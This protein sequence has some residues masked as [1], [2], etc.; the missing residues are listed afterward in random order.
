MTIVITGWRSAISEEFRRLLSSKEVVI[1]GKPMEPDFPL[2][3]HRYLFCQGLLRPKSY[4]DQ[5]AAEIEEGL[6]VNYRSIERVCDRIF[7]RNDIARVCIIGSESGYR[8]SFDENYACG[9]ALMHRY[10]ESKVLRTPHQQLVGISPWIIGDCKMTTD[11]KDVDNLQRKRKEHPMQRFLDAREVASMARTLLYF[12]NF[13][14]GT[15]IRM[16]GGLK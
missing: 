13:V 7:D 15:V 5:T 1:H 11:R 16:H 3:A 14:S 12:Q 10:I 6:E 8:G 4:E 9:K 2:K